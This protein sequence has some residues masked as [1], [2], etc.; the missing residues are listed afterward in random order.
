MMTFEFL[1]LRFKS[2]FLQYF[3]KK[4]SFYCNPFLVRKNIAKWVILKYATTHNHPQPSAITHNHPQP[5]TTSHNYLQPFTTIHNHPKITEKGQNL[6]QTVC[7]C[8]KMLIMKQTL[9]LIVIWNNAHI[10]VCVCV[11]ILYKSFYL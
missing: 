10:Y 11:Y 1:K 6:S 9:T 3:S 2:H 5:A 8:T 7:Y 4:S